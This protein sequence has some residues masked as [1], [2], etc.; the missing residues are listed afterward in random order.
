MR[1]GA[2]RGQAGHFHEA[3]FYRSDAEFGALIMPFA[4]EGIAAGEPVI[5]GY[6][7][8]KSAL[9]RS[10]LTDSSAV[11]FVGDE[12]LYAKPARAI[13]AYRRLFELHLAMGAGQI[14]I[15]GDV[16]HPGNG[17]R[18][19][20][21][22]RY[23]A[24]VNTVWQDF[25]VWGRCLYDTTT[26][27]AAVLD[28][29]ER[30]HPRLVSPSGQRRES[31]RYQDA[32]VFEG[33]PYAPDPLEDSTPLAELVNRP[34][35]DA[36]H[37]LARIAHSHIPGT[38]VQDLLIGV[39]EAVTNAHRHGRPPVTVRIWAT[40]DRV[41]VTV[42]DTGHGPADRLVGLVPVPSST[43]DP[44]RGMGLWVT[45][46]LDIDV[47]LRYAG[48]GFTIRLRHLPGSSRPA[49]TA[50]SPDGPSRP[51]RA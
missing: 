31:R 45:H 40:P 10:W 7:D 14:R 29:V 41:V 19:E 51:Q 28:V 15:A 8:R 1:T 5:L 33:L 6:D 34:A 4:E 9:L 16:P 48:D 20:G 35:A 47:T 36:R 50:G 12:S 23:E 17:G 42:H 37:T 27:P 3:G 30:T 13:A 24:A 2:A 18:F 21:W 38:I 43:P 11:E 44:H 22:D 32:L 25:P 46:Q 49:A 26:A 39:T